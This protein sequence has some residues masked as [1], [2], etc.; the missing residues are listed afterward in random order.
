MGSTLA[1]HNDLKLVE[2]L[3]DAFK[4][5]LNRIYS[6]MRAHPRMSSNPGLFDYLWE[7]KELAIVE[8][9]SSIEIPSGWLEELGSEFD[10]MILDAAHSH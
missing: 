8:K 3:T 7:V 10:E 4:D 2:V 5:R 6:L 9:R 1:R